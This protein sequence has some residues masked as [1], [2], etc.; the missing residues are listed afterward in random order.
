MPRKMASPVE[1]RGI[2]YSFNGAEA[3]MPRKMGCWWPRAETSK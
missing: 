1:Y 3:V 2:D